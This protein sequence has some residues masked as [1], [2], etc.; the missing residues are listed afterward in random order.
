MKR[1]GEVRSVEVVNGRA[2]GREG[3]I[4]DR[5]RVTVTGTVGPVRVLGLAVGVAPFARRQR[6]AR[7]AS[8]RAWSLGS[9][10]AKRSRAER[11]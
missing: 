11:A 10:A 5:R 8:R 6:P 7:K 4:T 9:R 1:R 3:G 2:Q